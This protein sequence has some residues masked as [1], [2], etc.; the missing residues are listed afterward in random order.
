MPRDPPVTR[1]VRPC[2]GPV[3][4]VMP[5][6]PPPGRLV[7]S[8]TEPH[9]YN[10]RVGAQLLEVAGQLDRVLGGQRA[11]PGDDGHPA[12]GGLHVQLDDPPVLGRR[13][14]HELTGGAGGYET[15]D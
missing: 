10:D 1:T 4:D 14:G 7:I 6:S 3:D 12:R 15:V 13:Q 9:R 5:I 8:T 2:S 11:D